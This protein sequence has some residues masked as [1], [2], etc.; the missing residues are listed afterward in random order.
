MRKYQPLIL[1]V[2]LLWTAPSLR[3]DLRSRDGTTTDLSAVQ[4]AL[5]GLDRPLP[6][7]NPSP[8]DR[9]GIREEQ[10]VAPSPDGAAAHPTPIGAEPGGSPQGLALTSA[11]SGEVVMSPPLRLPDAPPPG[12]WWQSGIDE[13]LSV[14]HAPVSST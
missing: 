6:S 13:P 3:S 10:K 12:R 4:T 11:T 8:V 5:V 1:L 9:Y 7:V 14:P 2:V